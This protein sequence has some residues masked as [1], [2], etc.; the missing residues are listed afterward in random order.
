MRWRPH[1]SEELAGIVARSQV[2]SAALVKELPLPACQHLGSSSRM[3]LAARDARVRVAAA[4][5]VHVA[6][7]GEEI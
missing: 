5:Q 4:R 2:S 6:Q 1:G 3:D 7:E